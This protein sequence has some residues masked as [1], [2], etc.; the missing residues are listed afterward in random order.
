MFSLNA[1]IYGS[2]ERG[3]Q[4]VDD[5][6][7]RTDDINASEKEE[8]Q[9]LLRKSRE[10]SQAAMTETR[11]VHE[12]THRVNFTV[13]TSAADHYEVYRWLTMLVYF[14]W[15]TLVCLLLLLAIAC[16]SKCTLLWYVQLFTSPFAY[17]YVLRF[18]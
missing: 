12:R 17:P 16:S 2:V 15:M 5:I 14:G 3:L 18:N 10:Y 13:Y 6:F 7:K 4:R 11:H 8:L 9:R 1:S